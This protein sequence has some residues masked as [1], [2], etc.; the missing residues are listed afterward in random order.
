MH[1]FA[2]LLCITVGLLCPAH[3][4]AQQSVKVH[5]I[6]FLWPGS[7]A[8]SSAVL[9]ALR[10]GLRELGYDGN[11][12]ID[13][14]EKY[15]AGAMDRIPAL[16]SALLASKA[17]IIV[18]ASIPAALAATKAAPD[19]PIVVGAAGDFVGNRLAASMEKPGANITGVDEVVPGLSAK[20]LELLHEGVPSI[21]S[22]A[23]LSSATGPTFARQME[24][25]EKT[26]QSLGLTLK[27]YKLSSPADIEPS[28]AAMTND[29]VAALMV[30]SGALTAINSKAIVDLAARNKLPA[31]YWTT[32]FTTDGGL[33]YYGPKL[34][35]MFRQSAIIVHRI[36]N[37]EKAGEIP[38]QYAKEFELVVNLKAAHD[39]GITLPD[40]LLRK[41]DHV[42]Q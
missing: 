12:T 18:T 19:T 6:G 4:N 39:L 23:I 1:S 42:I 9:D 33:M 37:G 7:E 36:M 25:S 5:R 31:M 13:I 11:N 35:A 38:V 20:R 14:E 8:R 16:T 3:G 28:F 17:E 40:S 2:F 22:F 34:T 29:Q 41:A 21:R 24:E 10:K 32:Q 15:A 27:T 30:F 26:A